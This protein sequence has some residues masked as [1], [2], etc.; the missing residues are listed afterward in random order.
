M[1]EPVQ[2]QIAVDYPAGNESVRDAGLGSSTAPSFRHHLGDA[3]IATVTIACGFI[4]GFGLVSWAVRLAVATTMGESLLGVAEFTFRNSTTWNTSAAIVSMAALLWLL[5]DRHADRGA[6]ASSVTIRRLAVV[7]VAAAPL[8]IASVLIVGPETVYKAF[9]LPLLLERADGLVTMPALICPRTCPDSRRCESYCTNDDGY[10]DG[11]LPMAVTDGERVLLVGDSFVWGTGLQDADR[12]DVVLER[13]LRAGDP[14]RDWD[15]FNIAQPGLAFSAYVEALGHHVPRVRPAH[16]VIGYLER[17]DLL[18][19]DDWT[20]VR[21]LGNRLFA[22][23]ALTDVW[24]DHQKREWRRL[25]EMLA[26]SPQQLPL[27]VSVPFRASLRR[28]VELQERWGFDI[29]VLA[30]DGP[31]R[32]FGDVVGPRFRVVWLDSGGAP[33]KATSIPGDGHPTGYANR[34]YAQ[35]LMRELAGPEV[36]RLP[37]TVSNVSAP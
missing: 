2:S 20:R 5:R 23:M 34:K 26:A 35:L 6:M 32:L 27:E 22:A 16:V 17:N 12:L 10:R 11:P 31:S 33:D 13:S 29:T 25:D 18:R 4:V 1:S 14:N 7:A 36:A 28:L 30:Y 15:V 37:H 24:T 8:L 9:D 21:R 3:A 19:V